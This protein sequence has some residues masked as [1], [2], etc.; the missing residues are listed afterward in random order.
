MMLLGREMRARIDNIV[1]ESLEDLHLQTV[2]AK[3]W[4]SEHGVRDV[5]VARLSC[6]GHGRWLPKSRRYEGAH[7]S[8]GN[9]AA[10]GLGALYAQLSPSRTY[11]GETYVLSQQ[12]GN[13]V[14]KHWKKY[15]MPLRPDL[16]VVPDVKQ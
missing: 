8:L 9:M 3:I 14:V 15:A 5:E 7:Q 12:I 1:N 11:E 4:V 16:C 6:G 10:T 13:A 2:G